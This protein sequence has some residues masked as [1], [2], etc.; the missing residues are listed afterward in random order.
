MA[1]LFENQ[2]WRVT[3]SGLEAKS[4]VP[5]VY[6]PAAELLRK[7]VVSDGWLYEWPLHV[8]ENSWVDFP[9]FAEAFKEA[10]SHHQLAFN[11][12]LLHRSIAEGQ[13]R[14]TEL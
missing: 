13:N 4:D 12:E 7:R 10:L 2:Q 11:E 3:H 5:T 6:I 1:Q 9:A 14:K 8:A